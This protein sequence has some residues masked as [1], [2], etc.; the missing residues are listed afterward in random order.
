MIEGNAPS[1]F[2]KE[3]KS[4][5]KPGGELAVVGNVVNSS[6]ELSTLSTADKRGVISWSVASSLPPHIL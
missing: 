6:F 1:F 4:L 2:I 5:K 3:G